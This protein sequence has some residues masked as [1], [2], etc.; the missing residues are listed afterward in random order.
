MPLGGFDQ[1]PE[2]SMGNS[3]TKIF[4]SRTSLC[5]IIQFSTSATGSSGLGPTINKDPN[6]T[7][8]SLKEHF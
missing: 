2:P 3:S 1:G 4:G 7:L 5:G 6:R 8:N